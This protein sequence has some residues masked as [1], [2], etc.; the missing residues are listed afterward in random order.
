M[1]KPSKIPCCDYH[2][3]NN[4]N[5]NSDDDLMSL[6]Q[7]QSYFIIWVNYVATSL[8]SLTGIM[9]NKRNHPKMA[10]QFRL[11]KYYNL[12]R[13]VIVIIIVEMSSFHRNSIPSH[14][15]SDEPVDPKTYVISCRSDVVDAL[16]KEKDT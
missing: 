10:Q 16:L 6:S 4:N 7:S 13:I 5:N 9:G 11:V 1:E 15:E 14:H 8:F 12:P 2:N 3:N